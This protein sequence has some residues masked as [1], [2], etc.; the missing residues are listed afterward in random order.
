MAS[1]AMVGL[2][3]NAIGVT[4]QSVTITRFTC[5]DRRCS[6]GASVVASTPI[7]SCLGFPRT[8]N[9]RRHSH[10]LKRRCDL[11]STIRRQ[12]HTS[13]AN[14]HA[15]SGGNNQIMESTLLEAS[16]FFAPMMGTKPDRH[17]SEGFTKAHIRFL[18]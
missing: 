15:G 14:A 10:W 5:V 4:V 13:D 6:S 2:T 7:I 18:V 9:A 11:I 8:S 12:G 16:L 3:G 17:R 1:P